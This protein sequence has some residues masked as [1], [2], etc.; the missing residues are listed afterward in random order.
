MNG[1]V[2]GGGGLKSALT[3][4]PKMTDEHIR[5]LILQERH[6]RESQDQARSRAV[7]AARNEINRRLETMNDLRAQINSERGMFTSRELHD[8]DYRAIELRLNEAEGRISKG[9][10]N[11]K[12]T[13]LWMGAMIT[14]VVSMATIAMELWLRK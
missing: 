14:V 4:K 7:E 8:R 3:E 6:L 11:S 5:D 13:M 10:G 2:Q 9:E 1:S 12:A